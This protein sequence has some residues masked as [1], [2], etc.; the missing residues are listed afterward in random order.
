LFDKAQEACD[1]TSSCASAAIALQDSL[2]DAD[3]SRALFNK[4]E[5]L[6]EGIN[7]YDALLRSASRRSDFSNVVREGL[8][9]A[10]GKLSSAA[11]LKHL[12]ESVLGY[13]D[14]RG[15]AQRLYQK[16]LD[17]PGADQQRSDIILSIKNRLGDT[18]WAAK[19][20][21]QL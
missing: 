9:S 3:R 13:T 1:S 8:E 21:R 4:A 12:A 5:S 14:D 11:D 16:A 15:W 17:A 7:D 20:S 19:L 10:E 18:D 6:C 2:G